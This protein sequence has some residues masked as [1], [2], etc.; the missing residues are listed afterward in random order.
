MVTS[1]VRAFTVTVPA[2]FTVVSLTS[3]TSRLSPTTTLPAVFVIETS[4]T[5]PR[6]VTPSVPSNTAPFEKISLVAI[7]VPSMVTPSRPASIVR[8]VA[9]AL[10]FRSTSAVPLS[11]PEA[12]M[13]PPW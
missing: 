10:K 9:S 12:L 4:A 7:V 11:T 3:V 8:P 2:L 5:E 13:T 1:P 6:S